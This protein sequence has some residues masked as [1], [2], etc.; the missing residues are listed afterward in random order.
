MRPPSLGRARSDGDE[1]QARRPP[2]SAA[3]RD[4]HRVRCT[5]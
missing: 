3:M 1:E 2:T 4:D 5:I